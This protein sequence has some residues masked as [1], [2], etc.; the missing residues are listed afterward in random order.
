MVPVG[1]ARRVASL[2]GAAAL[3][4]GF[5]LPVCAHSRTTT[6]STVSLDSE[7][8]GWRIRVAARDLLAPLEMSE[9]LPASSYERFLPEAEAYVAKR[10][11]VFAG[12]RR[13]KATHGE[14]SWVP[15]EPAMVEFLNTY[16]CPAGGHGFRL[17]YEL[18]FDLDPLH[19][20]FL[21]LMRQGVSVGSDVFRTSHQD[22]LVTVTASAWQHVR[23][24]W[25]LGVEHIFT[26]YDHLAFLAGLLLLAA[27]GWGN[28]GWQANPPRQSLLATAKLVTAFTV[29]HSLTLTFAALQP[30]A[31]LSAWVEPSIAGSV[32]I[33]GA[34]NLLHRRPRRRW[35]LAF[36]F[37]LV[38]GFGFASVLQEIGLPEAGLLRALLAFNVGVECGQLVVVALVLPVLLWVARHHMRLYIKVLLQAGSVA[39]ILIGSFWM[40]QRLAG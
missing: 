17:H 22:H 5:A 38:H 24:F 21:Q 35:L 25:L 3:V 28:N 20:G 14:A 16:S 33:V 1:L 34:E 6:F 9:E 8:V 12:Q 32:A 31:L 4:A 27:V 7:Q 23:R 30:H 40:L 11:A 26:G 36:A 29:A 18:L 2:A 37:G 13:C 19:S 15:G 39:L 10:V